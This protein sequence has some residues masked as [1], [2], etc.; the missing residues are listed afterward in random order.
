MKQKKPQNPGKSV[1]TQAIKLKTQAKN[2]RIWQIHLVELPKTGP[3]QKKPV[4][5]TLE[6]LADLKM[7]CER[8]W[9]EKT[10]AILKKIDFMH[11][12]LGIYPFLPILSKW[13]EM[14]LEVSNDF[15]QFQE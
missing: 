8:N 5:S 11:S 9:R 10:L 2:S 1:K 7:W 15:L 12:W 13:I 14:H 4:L 6:L 3:N